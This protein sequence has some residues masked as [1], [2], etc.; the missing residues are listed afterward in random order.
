[1]VRFRVVVAFLLLA[2][3]T[4]TCESRPVSPAGDTAHVPTADATAVPPSPDPVAEEAR[5]FRVRYGLRADETWIRAVAAN[6][7]AK[8]GVVDFGVP[9]MPFERL[10]L[11]HRRTDVDLLRQI[12]DYGSLFPDSYAGAYVD[13][14]ASEAFVASFKGDAARHRTALANLLPVDARVDVRD[15]DWSTAEL[16]NFLRDV[17]AEQPWFETI[18]VRYLTADRGITDDFVS[19]DFLGP[20]DAAQVIED[21]FGDPT[22]LEA[23]RQ[24]PLPW[25]GPRGNLVVV[26]VDQNGKPVPGL[27]C[28]FV[29]EDPNAAEGGE[30][31]FG[32][33]KTGR[34]QIPNL[35]AVA[36]RI[37]LHRFVDEDHYE[38]IKQFRV[39]LAPG[40]TTTSVVVEMP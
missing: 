14:R 19:V 21:H 16:T 31:I 10:D 8:Q 17:E 39:V 23:D 13:Q 36:Y 29:S 3:A 4:T 9:L 25:A 20:E 30:D 1:M 5:R 40:G 15:V 24:G 38:P 32:T 18:G 7:T 34:C 35:P 12:N 28:Q 22:W 26:V 33:D 37:V 6:P 2:I 27:W 11:E